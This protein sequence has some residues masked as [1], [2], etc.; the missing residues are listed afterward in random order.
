VDAIGYG[1]LQATSD[2]QFDPISRLSGFRFDF[3]AD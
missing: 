1:R 2:L 3:S